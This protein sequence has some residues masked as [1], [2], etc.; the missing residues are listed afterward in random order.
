VSIVSRNQ[1]KWSDL[2]KPSNVIN[3]IK[4]QRK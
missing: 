1:I 2:I 3:F 4:Q